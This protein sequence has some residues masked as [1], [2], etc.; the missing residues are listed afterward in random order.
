M[1]LFDEN[2]AV[3][4]Q[5]RVITFIS[6]LNDAEATIQYIGTDEDGT[7]VFFNQEQQPFIIEP[8]IDEVNLPNSN[9]RQLI[10]FFGIASLDEVRRVAQNAHAESLFILIEPNP[11]FLQHA[12]H[13]EDFK[14]LDD[15]KYIIVSDKANNL[16]DLYDL[17]FST[18]F[19]N[20]TKN[21]V[22]YL[23]D[24]YRKYDSSSI[25]EYIKQIGAT[26]KNKLFIMGNSIEDSLIGL[27]NNM[28]N[29][30]AISYNPDVAKLKGIF[31]GVPA[32]V[33]AA[34]PSLDKNI[35]HLKKVQGKGLIIAVD[36]IAEK[37]VNH[38]IIPDFIA[39]VERGNIVYEYFYEKQ[40][41]PENTYLVSS[42]VTDPKIVEKFKHKAILPMRSR[43]REYFWLKE[44]LGLTD[45]HFMTMGLSCAHIALGLALHVGASPIVLVG[46]DLAGDKAKHASGTAYDEKPVMSAGEDDL[47]VPGYYGGQVKSCQIWVEFKNVFENI[48]RDNPGKF[49]INATEG[50][51]KIEGAEQQTLEAVVPK[52]CKQTINVYEVL[53]NLSFTSIDWQAAERRIR[54]YVY[55]LEKFRIKVANHLKSLT[56]FN[57]TWQDTMPK[58]K[59]KE[60]Y[61]VMKKTDIF[62]QAVAKDQ[63][64]FHN[65]QGPL[66][67]LMQKF[68]TIEE[69]DS[70]E[71]L[72]KNLAV[73]ID[74]CE[75][76]EN[77][78][79]LI[80]QVI[81]ENFPW[82][83]NKS[84]R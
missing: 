18:R 73:Q 14:L 75:M 27:A 3:I 53:R 37:L 84:Q 82:S 51:A 81:E 74:L 9:I 12:M 70:L 21:I 55:Q 28:K 11:Y 24:Y 38:G 8:A 10:F 69:T 34:G 23:N 49:I 65:V 30:K 63:L 45:N 76:L 41:Y 22:F 64:L 2:L 4:T 33:V 44:I 59:I 54:D 56:K 25:Q 31:D 6:E 77:T 42:L 39:T 17:L 58:S 35:D 5:N 80:I 50:G 47:L 15:I 13:Y 46:Q 40:T 29:I 71:S 78:A 60:V 16:I 66:A 19:F 43:V 36:T 57:E 79:W 32:F 61:D 52:Y 20:L 7:K 62:Y 72:R 83:L 26:L 68:Y 1:N 48:I 67:I